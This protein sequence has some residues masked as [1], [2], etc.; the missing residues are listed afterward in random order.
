[1]PLRRADTLVRVGAGHEEESN[2]DEG[3][4]D[5]DL[6]ELCEFVE[7]EIRDSEREQGK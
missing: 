5:V 2:C 1:M 3:V 7:E 6:V 4:V